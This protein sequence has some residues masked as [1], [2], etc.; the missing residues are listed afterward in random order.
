MSNER[1]AYVQ[2]GAKN[3]EALSEFYMKALDF[4]PANRDEWLC[5]KNGRTF[6][7][8]GFEYG[9]A[10]VFG[11]VEAENGAASK[12]NDVGFAHICFETRNVK[13]ALRR[14]IKCGGTFVSTLKLPKINPCVYCADPEGNIVEFHIPFPAEGTFKEKAVMAGSLLGL[15]AD[16]SLRFIHVN[17]I[18]ED[19]KKTIGFYGSICDSEW[20]GTLKDHSGGYKSKVIGIDGVH[21][22]GQHLLLKGLGKGFPTLEIFSYSV[23]GKQEVCDETE[24]GINAIGFATED[25][26]LLA[27]AI[28]KAGGSVI[29]ST[30]DRILAADDQNGRIY[31]M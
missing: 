17:I 27:D 28:V 25:R 30:P 3:V 2:I 6:Y 7:C 8:P 13:A 15:M 20:F 21:V 22:V 1:F 14:F 19:W 16:K 18:S 5:G 24:L 11:I 26:S 10:P 31:I 23:P 29:E 4:V 12:I 9:L